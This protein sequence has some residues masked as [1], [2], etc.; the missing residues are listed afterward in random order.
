MFSVFKNSYKMMS[1]RIYHQSKTIGSIIL[2]AK[3]TKQ[4]FSRN[5]KVWRK[6]RTVQSNKW[7]R[8]NDITSLYRVVNQ[9]FTLLKKLS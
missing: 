9:A 7:T 6:K 2:L 3:Y 5:R 1:R 4:R 8:S